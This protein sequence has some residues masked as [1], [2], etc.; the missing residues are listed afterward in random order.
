MTDTN[1]LRLKLEQSGYKL[2]FVAAQLGISYQGFVNKVENRSEF[3]A[4]EIGILRE[5]LKLSDFEVNAIFFA[6]FVDKKPTNDKA[7]G[8]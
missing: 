3:R 5:L 1:L 8:L 7:A 4:K 6:S 2:R